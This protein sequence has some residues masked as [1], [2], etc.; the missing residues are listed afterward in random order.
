MYAWATKGFGASVSNAY[1]LGTGISFGSRDNA[2]KLWICRRRRS[3]LDKVVKHL[4][5]GAAK[6]KTSLES[7]HPESYHRTEAALQRVRKDMPQD[8]KYILL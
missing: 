6:Q 5:S 1:I 2:L 4:L 7:S 3:V 8:T